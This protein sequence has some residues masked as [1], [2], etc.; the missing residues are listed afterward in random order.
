MQRR[1][2]KTKILGGN[3]KNAFIFALCI[4]PFAAVGGFFTGSYAYASY[5]QKMQQEIIAQIG[6]YEM[7]LIAAALQSV[8]YAFV[9]GVA[10]YMASTAVGLMRPFGLEK[11]KWMP[12]SVITVVCG[13]LFAMDY[14]TFGKVL[15]QVAASYEAGTT[16]YRLDNWIAS[17]LYGGIVEEVLLRLFFMSV[18]AYLLW[19]IFFRKCSKEQIPSGVFAAANIISA[20]L[21]AAGHLPATIGM[22]GGLSPVIILRCFLL[23]GGLGLVFGCFYW[24]YGIQ[25]AMV[26]HMGC[27]II[28]KLIWMIFLKGV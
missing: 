7:L 19:I 20:L 1:M 23:N 15:P 26:G 25:Y 11:A 10:G 17:I 3:W 9:C 8:M 2:F 24:K 21:F 28:S 18:L 6:S 4:I 22:F 14:W 12:V 5:G 16:I 27:H 13:I